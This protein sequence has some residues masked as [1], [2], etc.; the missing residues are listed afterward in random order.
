[1]AALPPTE[2]PA[3]EP[4]HNSHQL[5]FSYSKSIMS[6]LV[7]RQAARITTFHPLRMNFRISCPTYD[8]NQWVKG[9]IYNQATSQIFF[10]EN[11]V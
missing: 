2:L 10:V 7:I 4:L 3:S 9:K 11:I 8:F 6:F 5:F 1:V